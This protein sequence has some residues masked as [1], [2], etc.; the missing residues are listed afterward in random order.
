[1]LGRSSSKP[2]RSSRNSVLPLDES[3]LRSLMQRE[4]YTPSDFL[5]E[6][7][8]SDFDYDAKALQKSDTLIRAEVS[9][10]L[11]RD[12]VVDSSDIEVTVKD[13]EVTLSGTVSNRHEKHHAAEILTHVAGVRDIQ[14]QLRVLR[15]AYHEDGEQGFDAQ[16]W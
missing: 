9:E 15:S 13:G 5:G 14:N 11:L 2:Q 1:M 4:A 3:S 6:R 16:R 7:G 10:I 12:S 8:D